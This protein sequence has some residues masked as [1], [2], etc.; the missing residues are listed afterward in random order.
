MPDLTKAPSSR[1]AEGCL[2]SETLRAPGHLVPLL[3][4]ALTGRR[5]LSTP[6]SSTSWSSV[7]ITNGWEKQRVVFKVRKLECLGWRKLRIWSGSQLEVRTR[8]I[9]VAQFGKFNFNYQHFS[10]GLG[11]FYLTELGGRILGTSQHQADHFVPEYKIF[12]GIPLELI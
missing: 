6:L 10:L 11:S 2:F 5:T 9:S 7:W 8:N 4:A 1:A 3:P 12:L